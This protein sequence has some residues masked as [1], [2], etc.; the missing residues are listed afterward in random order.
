M[1]N[2]AACPRSALIAWVRCATS[3]SR[4]FTMIVAACCSAVLSGTVRIAGR[5]AASPI[6]SA[7]LRSFLFRLTKGFTYCGGISFTRWPRRLNKRPQWCDPAQASSATSVG[8]SLTKNGFELATPDLAPQNR[9]LLLVDSVDRE[10]MLG[11]VD[12]DAFKFHLGGPFMVRSPT[13][14]WHIRCRRAVH[15]V[16]SGDVW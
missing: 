8:S 9:M 10:D 16:P 11:G 13:Q 2:S 12:R 15:P 14:W 1:P 4:C 5:D 3:I 6:A 7:S